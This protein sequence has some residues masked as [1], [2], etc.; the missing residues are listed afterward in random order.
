MMFTSKIDVGLARIWL[1]IGVPYVWGGQSPRK[2]WDCS[3]LVVEYLQTMGQMPAGSDAT[4]QMLHDSSYINDTIVPKR[5]DLVFLG[6]SAK[7]IM[8]CGVYIHDGLYLNAHGKPD[9][10]VQVRPIDKLAY[11]AYADPFSVDV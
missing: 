6:A 4:A 1:E 7:R 11:L 5:G 2:V 10:V 9:S 3:G 8:H